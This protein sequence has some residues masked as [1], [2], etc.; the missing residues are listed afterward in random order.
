MFAEWYRPGVKLDYPKGGSEGIINA[1]VRGIEKHGGKV[2]LKQHV[3]QVCVSMPVKQ[4][5][6]LLRA[7]MGGGG[8]SGYAC[9]MSSRYMCVPVKQSC[10]L[11]QGVAD[12]AL[13]FTAG[14]R[15]CWEVAARL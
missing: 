15:W 10:V 12:R 3:E 1:L 13:S 14:L 8:K 5:C 6:A 11:L 7:D 9:S 4:W 2:V